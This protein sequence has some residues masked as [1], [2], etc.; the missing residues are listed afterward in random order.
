MTGTALQTGARTWVTWLAVLA[1]ATAAMLALRPSLDKA[2]LALG[3]LLIV[4]GASARSGRR[5]GLTIA[6]LA[7]IALNFFFIPPYHT[8]LVADA[9]DWLVLAAF[10]VTGATAAQ[11]LS[12]VRGEAAA[13]RERA[14][15]IDRISVL[16]AE[17]LNAG[18]AE[19]ALEAVAKA[20]RDTLR[21]D[22]CE[23]YE[24]RDGDTGVLLV[25]ISGIADIDI[26]SQVPDPPPERGIAV[27]RVPHGLP[28]TGWV[29]SSG[30]V[31]VEQDDG[32]IYVGNSATTDQALHEMVGRRIRV[33]II[34]LRVRERTVGVLRLVSARGWSI[35]AASRRVLE[36]LSYYAAL[37][38][39]R[40]GLTAAAEHAEALRQADALKDALLAS[41]S[42]DLRT[43]LTTIKALAQQIRHDGDERA[44][45]IEE[46]A[47]R[48]NRFVADLLDLSR[49][50]GGALDVAP[51]VTAVEDLIGA[52]LQ[53][54]SG[55]PGARDIAVAMDPAEPLLLGRFDFVHAL[56]VLVN[57]IENALKYAPD[58]PTE[59][60][61]ARESDMVSITVADRGPGVAA[62]EQDRIFE[63]FYRPARGAP[64]AAGAGLG[65]SIARSLAEAQ[66]GTVRYAPRAGGGS[67]FT[68][69]LPAADIAEFGLI[70]SAR[71]TSL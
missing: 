39:E 30:R 33:L 5:L 2:H 37:G 57:L 12:R 60:G 21:V 66:G 47:D 53:R 44:A 25:G 26:P 8:L 65:L 29:A 18:R 23:I 54:V 46:E 48:L 10:L 17:A 43:P 15:E 27:F 24:R 58:A 63:P 61:A 20:V 64:G 7:F 71:G 56:R 50:A 4:L 13:A 68:L 40:V 55:S 52:A 28:L 11:L 36:A 49:I 3:Y 41:V 35:D 34:P 67:I 45:T 32:G 31:A 42:H 70:N 9:R 51:E 6:V 1:G 19:Q 62:S 22:R 69:T 14:D 59:L 38:L 16:G